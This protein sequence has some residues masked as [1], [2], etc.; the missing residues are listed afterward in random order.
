[1]RD[2]RLG[3]H[4]KRR[5]PVKSDFITW[6]QLARLRRR[7]APYSR[8]RRAR[9]ASEVRGCQR[10]TVRGNRSQ[11]SRFPRP[12]TGK[13]STR[14]YVKRC[15]RCA[16]PVRCSAHDRVVASR[17][18]LA[19]SPVQLLGCTEFFASARAGLQEI[20]RIP[21]CSSVALRPAHCKG[22]EPRAR[23][24]PPRRRQSVG[25][26]GITNQIPRPT[27]G[28]HDDHPRPEKLPA[29]RIEMGGVGS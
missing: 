14:C 24:V 2:A 28:R 16:L 13:T 5:L 11:A 19:P 6:P 17:G 8:R 22:V 10:G 25:G 18:D 1:V 9:C 20:G 27:Q 26:V 23:A 29:A 15:P 12:C 3:C 21:R 4:P 7:S